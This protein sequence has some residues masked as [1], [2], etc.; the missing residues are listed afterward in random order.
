MDRRTFLRLGA[1]GSTGLLLGG[2]AGTAQTGPSGSAD[3]SGGFRAGPPTGSIVTRWD[4][5][6]WS[7]GSYSALPAGTSWR[8]RQVLADAVIG[9]RVV[10]AGEYTATDYPAT[11]H[12]AYGSGLRAAARLTS[13]L[14]PGARV[15]VVGAGLAGLAAATSLVRAGFGVQ[16]LEARDRVGGRVHTDSSLGA[17]V[18]LGAAW[19]HGVAGNPM[20]ELVAAAGLRLVPTDFDDFEAR[21]YRDGRDVT[22]VSSADAELTRHLTVIADEEPPESLTVAGALAARGWVADTEERRLAELTEVVMDY[23]LDL[24]RLGAQALW[25]GRDY[26]GGDSLVSGGFSKVPEMLARAVD[27]QLGAAATAVDITDS[28]VAVRTASGELA[29]AGVVVA[30]PLALLAADLPE[31]ALPQ[32]ARAAV[33]GLT[34]GH[35]EKVVLAYQGQ[36]WP[37]VQV[38]QVMSAPGGLWSEWYDLRRV[39]GR[40]LVV[41]FSG[42]GGALT[43]PADDSA[44][45]AQAARALES[46]FAR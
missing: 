10:F 28:G 23:G 27:V 12:G 31:I 2:C 34:T 8:A 20:V 21:S 15:V 1:W 39:T 9:S 13:L 38:M 3:P 6:Q 35:L 36:W 30:V 43:R 18:E 11:V 42:G 40:P 4:S 33:N 45:V 25:E 29:A 24:D 26:R 41:G 32:A 22:G 16:V 46:A 44:C 17:P 19:I 14:S 37:S 7:R 5:D